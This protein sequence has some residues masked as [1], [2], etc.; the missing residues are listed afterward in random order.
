MALSSIRSLGVAAALEVT[1]LKPGLC[2]TDFLGIDVV[3][4]TESIGNIID[5]D[6]FLRVWIQACWIIIAWGIDFFAPLC[7]ILNVGKQLHGVIKLYGYVR[8]FCTERLEGF[9]KRHNIQIYWFEKAGDLVFHLVILTQILFQ[10]LLEFLRSVFNAILFEV[11]FVLQILII[12]TWII[13]I[14]T[15]NRSRICFLT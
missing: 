9:L 4:L 2:N 11:F 8:R 10:N 7:H 5:L 3:R 14:Q 6:R 12:F 15:S 1:P 13:S